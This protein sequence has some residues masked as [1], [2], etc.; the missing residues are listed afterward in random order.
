MSRIRLYIADL[1]AAFIARI[2]AA[3]AP[4]REIEIVGTA[5][6]GAVALNDIQRLRPDVLL[7]DIP[8]PGLDGIAL[9]RE[10]HRMRKPPAVIVCTRFYSNASM[11]CACKYGAS[12]FLCKP[13][14]PASLP[15]LILE[16]GGTDAAEEPAEADAPRQR[17]SEQA[18]RLL[19]RL[20][21]PAKLSGSGYLLEAALLAG[22]DPLLMK[23]L[24]RGVYC[25]LASRMGTTV[26]RVERC[27][28]SAI[29]VAYD[30]GEL[31][32]RFPSRP[33][34]RELLDYL[35]RELDAMDSTRA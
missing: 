30:R 11:E 20:G 10:A 23:N 6:D 24:S 5:S 3:A 16:C 18:K 15:R 2:R 17:R 22:D 27:L 34:N 7:T 28:R 13:V 12:F 26:S 33:S 31:S 1:D 9:L 8:L 14:E 35:L 32:A 19:R 4:C 25:Q 29:S 21:F